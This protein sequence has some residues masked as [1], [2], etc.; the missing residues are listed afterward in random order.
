MQLMHDPAGYAS[1]Q[2]A[3]KHLI[4]KLKVQ[5]AVPVIQGFESPIPKNWKV[6]AVTKKKKVKLS[7]YMPWRH[8][9]GEEV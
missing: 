6:N 4:Q 2:Y 9:G 7:R 3:T 1:Q 8:M 5:L